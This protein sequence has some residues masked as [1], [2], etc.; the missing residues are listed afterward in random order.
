MDGCVYSSGGVSLLDRMDSESLIEVVVVR[1]GQRVIDRELLF[2]LVKS[3]FQQMYGFMYLLS[4]VYRKT[5]I[6]CSAAN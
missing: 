5:F 1:Y 2:L 6:L 4:S 3:V